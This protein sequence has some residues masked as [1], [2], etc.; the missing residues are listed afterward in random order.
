MRNWGNDELVGVLK[1]DEP[2]VEQ[3]INAGRL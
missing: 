3:M 2:A 1:T